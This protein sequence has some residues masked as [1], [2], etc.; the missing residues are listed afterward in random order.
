ML[1]GSS[2]L[3][4]IQGLVW[5]AVRGAQDAPREAQPPTPPGAQGAVLAPDGGGQAAAGR[6]GVG[7]GASR[8]PGAGHLLTAAPR[9]ALPAPA[10]QTQVHS[11]ARTRTR[12]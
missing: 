7:S 5:G 6:R 11:G 3:G 9:D 1:A 10:A 2:G 4:N 12:P 8:P